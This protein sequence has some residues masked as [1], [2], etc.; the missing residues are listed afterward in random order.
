MSDSIQHECGIAFVRLL[1]DIPYYAQENK[2][3][4]PLYGLNQLFLLM[5]K[6]HNRGQDGAGIGCVKLNVPNGEPF[7][8]RDRDATAQALTNLFT[9]QLDAYDRART[10]HPTIGMPL[11]ANGE[12]FKRK[13]D[14]G[15]ELLLG[16][17]R[18]GTSG[19]REAETSACHPFYRKSIWQTRNLMLA[20]NFNITN[21]GTLNRNLIQRGAH[22][23][24]G[25]DTQSL[26]EEI[27]FWLD[28]EHRALYRRFNDAPDVPADA[29]PDAISRELNLARVLRE[30]ARNWDGAYSLV[31][32][33]GNGDA[34]V[35][36]DPNGIR[37]CFYI[38]NEEVFAVASERAALMTI[39]NT[40]KED[41]HEL[42]AGA[43]AIIKHDGAF[44]LEQILPRAAAKHCSFERIYFSR[45]ND[46]EIYAER[47]ALGAALAP[48]VYR[49]IEGDFEHS[50][51]SFIP[52][53]AE[54]A[55]YGLIHELYRRWRQDAKAA[56]LRAAAEG[57]LNKR[58][59]N[60][61]LFK[62]W[63]RSE[64]VAHK[65]IK[66]R[67]FIANEKNRTKLASHV[68]DISY[69]TVRKG[70]NLVVI[71]DSIVRGTTLRNSILRIL[72]RPNPKRIIVCSTA[73]QIRYP[74]CYGID[75]S[76][77]GEFLIFQ[78]AEALCRER[79]RDALLDDVLEK[80]LAQA[81]KPY[82]QM[83]NHVREIYAPFSEAELAAKASEIVSAGVRKSGW[84][85]EVILV[86]QTIE[87][88][89]R[90]CPNSPG[91]WYFTGEYPT[92]GGYAVLNNAYIQ[93]RTGAGKERANL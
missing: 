67:T 30:A 65:D 63:P 49:A 52:N 89:H 87:N 15:G 57:R 11:D 62:T 79:G 82:E 56:I 42:D 37:P 32:L 71:D 77:L 66:L 85:G 46:P 64:K 38:R 41:V 6:Q 88:L 74:D 36:R 53:T 33:V 50:V 17:L 68:Y 54:I 21:S 78:A 28:E 70:D 31:G 9:R 44:S 45:G 3:R 83:R 27:G 23:V 16:H 34:F 40:R 51:I 35:F 58:F 20:G 25:T 69:G 8:F 22:P 61:V 29:I 86:F 80:C 91:D 76:E 93:Y 47:K 13:F 73:P 12:L 72:S 92:P 90:A 14:F 18:Y 84:T 2:Y 60:Q 55:F 19:G 24:F 81:D 43:A 5:E 7:M 48:S 75:M 4:T 1:K 39:F 10:A 59:L 26:L